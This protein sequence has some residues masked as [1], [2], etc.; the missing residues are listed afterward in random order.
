MSQN[1]GIT[2]TA[3]KSADPRPNRPTADTRKVYD[4]I[5]TALGNVVNSALIN[6]ADFVFQAIK[7]R[8]ESLAVRCGHL[9][10]ATEC[11]EIAMTHLGQLKSTLN[12]RMRV[13][14]ETNGP[15]PY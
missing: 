12:H 1:N 2:A 7:F 8:D 14:D 15:L 13:E 3:N 10:D 9:V 4:E 6:S 5:I 11:L